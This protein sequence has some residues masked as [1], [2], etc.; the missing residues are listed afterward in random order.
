MLLKRQDW[1]IVTLTF[2]IGMCAGSYTYMVGFA[3]E[4]EDQLVPTLGL[5]ETTGDF[6]IRAEQYGGMRAG[7]PATITISPNGEY[8]Y[9]P[10]TP[11]GSEPQVQ[12]GFLPELYVEELTRELTTRALKDAAVEIE[13]EM[14]AVFVDGVDYRY[15]VTHDGADYVLDTCGTNITTNEGLGA[16]LSK[17]WTL[18]ETPVETMT[19]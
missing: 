8:E 10:F 11:T 6:T 2:I 7:S 13:P 14:C 17:V 4:F 12:V 19:E 5:E 18:F 3:P 1:V 15:R 9:T 16:T